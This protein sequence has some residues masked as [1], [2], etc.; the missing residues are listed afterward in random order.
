M[1]MSGAPRN[2]RDEELLADV[3]TRLIGDV[4]HV[5]VGNAT[6]CSRLTPRRINA[7]VACIGTPDTSRGT[8]SMQPSPMLASASSRDFAG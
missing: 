6:R 8:T 2:F 5:A 4:R 3:I 7:R 1:S